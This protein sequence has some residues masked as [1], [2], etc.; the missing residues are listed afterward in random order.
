MDVLGDAGGSDTY[1]DGF[2]RDGDV[3]IAGYIMECGQ[4]DK[5]LDS[6]CR[7]S[8]IAEF[9]ACWLRLDLATAWHSVLA[10]LPSIYCQI[11]SGL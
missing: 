8:R 10:R 7:I 2:L 3:L 9:S 4:W 6:T 11:T 1:N 5:L